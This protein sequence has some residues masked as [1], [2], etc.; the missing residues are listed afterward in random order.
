MIATCWFLAKYPEYANKIREETRDVDLNDKKILETLPQLN[1]FINETLR[2]VPPIMTGTSRLTG[3][4][5]LTLNGM[6]I[7]PFTR[8]TTPRYPIMRCE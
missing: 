3:P 7:P 1:G 4:Q 5:G 2:M 6:L 8:V